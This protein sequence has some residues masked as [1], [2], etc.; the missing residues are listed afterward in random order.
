MKKV[1]V[2]VPTLTNKAGGYE[3]LHSI[4]GSFDIFWMPI[5]I[6]NWREQRTLSTSWNIGIDIA[7]TYECDFILIINDDVLF[8]PWT[9]VGLI[10]AYEKEFG[11]GV[12]MTTGR[13]IRDS[14]QPE[15]IFNIEIPSWADHRYSEHPDFSCFLIRPDTF[16]KVGR[17]DENFKP[18]YFEDNDYHRRITLLGYK[19][20]AT[21]WAPYYHY[22]SL[23]QNADIERGNP[24]VHPIQFQENQG[25][26]SLKWGGVPGQE[27]FYN[28]YNDS[29]MT[30]SQWKY[31]K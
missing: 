3:A 20:I 29:K 10:A 11:T 13:N 16:Y 23:T 26:Y 1:G 8:S 17:F 22:G 31:L 25:Y 4:K 27:S 5:I 18:A 24:V 6:D 19:A 2:V 14:I 12:G 15:E 9:L 30:P 21:E 7:I 28:P